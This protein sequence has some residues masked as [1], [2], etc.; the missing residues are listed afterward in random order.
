MIQVGK[1]ICVRSAEL[2]GL[3]W[4][5][6]TIY[7]VWTLARILVDPHIPASWLSPDRRPFRAFSWEAGGD[8]YRRVWHIEAWKG[9]LPA[10]TGGTRFS[11]RALTGSDPEY[12][13][14]FIVETCRG[15]SNHA[16]AIGSVVVMKLWTPTALWVVM[17]AIAVAGNLPFI[18]I[19][20][21]NRPRLQHA[22]E[23]T[24]HR[25]VLHG[26]GGLQAGPA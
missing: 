21:Y 16:R 10:F 26:A 5:N 6:F 9:R 13:N 19:Q 12:L 2:V 11:K 17:L 25:A 4:T 23:V 18:A 14:Q 7:W 3:F 1:G 24:G 8:Y 15:E 20:R 22:L